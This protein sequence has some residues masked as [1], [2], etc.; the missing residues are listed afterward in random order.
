MAKPGF[1]QAARYQ[2]PRFPNCA[3]VL[4]VAAR[5]GGD[6]GE[7]V[8]HGEQDRR[9]KVGSL[10][11]TGPASR[12]YPLFSSCE[13]SLE[14]CENC[15]GEGAALEG[16]GARVSQ[17]DRRRAAGEAVVVCCLDSQPERQGKVCSLIFSP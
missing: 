3:F 9:N 1:N 13:V 5:G 7:R 11:S 2:S 4:V 17:E 8:G 12:L 16:S 10:Q 6:G 14:A 15:L